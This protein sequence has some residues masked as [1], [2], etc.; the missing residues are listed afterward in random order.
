MAQQDVLIDLSRDAAGGS[1]GAQLRRAREE[2]GLSIE[3]VSHAIKLAPRQVEAIE[4]DDFGQL[5][6]PTYVRGFIRNY[7]SLI[8]LDAKALLA[9]LDQQHVRA[10]PQLVEQA[11]VGV[12]MP[13]RSGQRRWLLP[14]VAL[15]VPLLAALVLYVWFEFWPADAAPATDLPATDSTVVEAVPPSVAQPEPGPAEATAPVEPVLQSAA[16]MAVDSAPVADAAIIEPVP[17]RLPG[18]KELVFSFTADSWVEIRDGADAI[19]LSELNRAGSSRTVNASFP[20]SV[21]IGNAHAVTLK[22][23]GTPH[24]LV[25]ATKVDV[26]RLRFE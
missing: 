19:I 2:R 21:V 1:V 18:Q 17:A 11:N 15:S 16:N 23:D 10:T 24:D 25:P 5:M 6:S 3:N 9:R 13:I 14:L 12:A 7:A 20:I 22:V 8:G 26:A 4:A